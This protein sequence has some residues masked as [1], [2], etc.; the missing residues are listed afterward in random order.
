MDFSVTRNANPMPA[1]GREAI[2][3]NP[4]FGTHFTDH[5]VVVVWEKDKGWHS[6]AVVPYGPI[7]MDPSSSV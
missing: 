4:T 3:A 1:P 5:Q 2:L 7:M 6:A